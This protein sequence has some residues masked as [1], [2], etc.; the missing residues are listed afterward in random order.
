MA[1]LSHILEG[2]SKSLG[3]MGVSKADRALSNERLKICATCPLAKESKILRLLKGNEHHIHVIYCTACG[4]PVNEK[5][6]VAKEYCPKGNW[7][8]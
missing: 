7:P 1:N 4:C 5:S 2:W 3:L 8:E 6:L